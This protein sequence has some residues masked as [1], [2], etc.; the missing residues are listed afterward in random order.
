MASPSR[1]SDPQRPW[2]A[3]L[4]EKL[5]AAAAAEVTRQGSRGDSTA[6]DVGGLR[7]RLDEVDS[8]PEGV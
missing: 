3:P 6:D 5:F 1:F 7:V 8:A 2:A 4:P